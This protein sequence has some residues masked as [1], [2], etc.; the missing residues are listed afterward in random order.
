MRYLAL[1]LATLFCVG[2]SG[3]GEPKKE[4]E[5]CKRHSECAEGLVCS[6]DEQKCLTT[7]NDRKT[8]HAAN[9]EEKAARLKEAASGTEDK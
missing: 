3:C 1:I 5:T 2:I 6:H 7:E 9:A 8:R 4:G